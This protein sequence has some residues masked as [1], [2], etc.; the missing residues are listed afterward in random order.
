MLKIK[1]FRKK[2][3][4][5]TGVRLAGY[6]SDVVSDGIHDELYISGIA[7]S[8][9]KSKKILLSYDLLG[10]DRPLVVKIRRKCAKILKIKETDVVLCCTHT[11]SGPHTRSNSKINMRNLEYSGQLVDW[12]AESVTGSFDNMT[13]V[14]VYLYSADVF[15]NVNR[16]VTLPGNVFAYLPF[17]KHLQSMVNGITD[18]ELGMV[19]FTKKGGSKLISSIVNYS[20]HPLSSQSSGESSLKI[21]SDYP[22]VLRKIVERDLGGLC[23]FVTGA[24]GDLHPVNFESGFEKTEEMGKNL[25]VKVIESYSQALRIREC[26]LKNYYLETRSTTVKL[27]IKNG[28]K[29]VLMP[30]F[31]NK[32][33]EKAE[34]H[35]LKIGDVCFVGVP[36]ELLC[37]PGMEI[38]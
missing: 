33:H 10:M 5:V 30:L 11:H 19:F 36:G 3:T 13:A 26:K 8:D 18:P 7:F 31:K 17:N 14:D 24:C 28:A 37:E 1:A 16:R 34:I 15:E 38:K 27:E 22:G 2:I 20:A 25:A 32:K 4:P 23:V 9:G 21:T 29:S 12:S 35:F 6:G